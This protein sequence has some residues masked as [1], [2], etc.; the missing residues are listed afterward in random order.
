MNEWLQICDLGTMLS[1][2]SWLIFFFLL[3][4]VFHC[5]S[6]IFTN[7]IGYLMRVSM[8]MRN[9]E[10]VFC[11]H[12]WFRI[13]FSDQ[14]MLLAIILSFQIFLNAEILGD[15]AFATC[16][17]ESWSGLWRLGNFSLI[18][19]L[20]YFSW[21]NQWHRGG[22]RSTV[23]NYILPHTHPPVEVCIHSVPGKWQ[24]PR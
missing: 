1:L 23:I 15:I 13:R 10:F 7:I 9:E 2:L 14:C 11:M 6:V 17:P 20:Q 18:C 21:W 16:I 3:S 22:Y 5:Y 8:N 24:W 19:L 4:S 12:A